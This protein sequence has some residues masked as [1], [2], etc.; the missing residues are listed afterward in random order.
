MLECADKLTCLNGKLIF[1][2][3]D[4]RFSY[5]YVTF[6]VIISSFS[7]AIFAFFYPYAFSNTDVPFLYK[8]VFRDPDRE[9]HSR[10]LRH[11]MVSAGTS[12]LVFTEPACPFA[13]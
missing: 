12:Y 6:S 5:R 8:R 9:K 10:C 13:I 7:P 3:Y 11:P 4:K 2:C 1:S